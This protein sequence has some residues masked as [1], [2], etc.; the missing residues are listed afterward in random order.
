MKKDWYYGEPSEAG[1]YIVMASGVYDVLLWSENGGWDGLPDD[2]MVTGFLP[3]SH[4]L[5]ALSNDFPF[6]I[7]TGKT[8]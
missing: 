2:A 8:S 7:N 1:A 3:A 5:M 4:F 6:E